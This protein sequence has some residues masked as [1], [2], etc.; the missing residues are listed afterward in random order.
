MKTDNFYVYLHIRKD[1]GIPFYVGKGS[2]NRAK[3]KK[4]RNDW[5]WNIV[6]KYGYDIIFLG[7]DLTEKESFDLECYWIKRIGR[8]ELGLGTLVN[9][10]DGGEGNS[11]NKWTEEQKKQI[12]IDRKGRLPWNTGKKCPQLKGEK[13]GM[14]GRVK[15]Q[16]PFFGKKHS[17]ESIKIMSE[18]SK[19]QIYTD[20]VKRKMSENQRRGK[21]N[22]SKKVIDITT[23]KIFDCLKDASDF[24][25]INYS[26]LRN[27]LNPKN[28]SPNKSNLRW[29]N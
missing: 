21:H 14:F 7:E 5:W 22:L 20:E 16:N 15:E 10:S 28:T 23:N 26:T 4:A 12:S 11:G 24:Y 8:R 19:N 25:N 2:G 27:W 13:N 18:K 17:E 29:Y 9:L 3:Q 6:N 1:N